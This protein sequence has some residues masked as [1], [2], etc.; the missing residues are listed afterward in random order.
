MKKVLFFCFVLLCTEALWAQY[1]QNYSA[2]NPA[3]FLYH[4][5]DVYL[6][7]PV[8]FNDGQQ[9]IVPDPQRYPWEATLENG[10]PNVT[11]DTDRD[12]MAIYLSSFISYSPTPPSKMGVLAYYNA[13]ETEPDAWNRAQ[14]ELYWFNPKGKPGDEA[15]SPVKKDG[16]LST[17]IVAVDIESV[18]LFEDK[19]AL[20]KPM[21]WIYLPQRES[22]NKVISAYEMDKTFNEQ[23]LLTGFW[24]MKNDRMEKQLNFT[25]DFINGDAHMNFYKVDGDYYFI[26][27]L[28][29][30]RSY[31]Q[32]GEVL[33]FERDPRKRYRRKTV[34]NVGPVLKSE[35]VDFS[36]A[37]DMATPQWEAYSVQPFQLD[38][39]EN[40]IWWGLVTTFGSA[41]FPDTEYKQRTELALTNDGVHWRW[42]KP[43]VPF[44]DNGP[45]P[46]SPDF[47]CIN[48]GKPV[49]YYAWDHTMKYLFYF[50]ASSP[51][52]H[53]AGRNSG[54]S[55]A[56]GTYGKIAGLH[57]D[58][59][60]KQFFSTSEDLTKG[61]PVEQLPTYSLASAFSLDAESFYPRIMADV[62]ED[63]R[64]KQLPQLNSYAAV[65]L[66]A[67]D[68]NQPHGMGHY[69][70]GSL[71]N[72][73]QGSMLPSDNFEAVSFVKG[74]EDGHSRNAMLQYLKSYSDEHPTEIVSIKDFPPVPVVMQAYV[75]NATLYS[76]QFTA[77]K[78]G[79]FP[80]DVTK[81][82][83]QQGKGVWTYTVP[84]PSQQ[85]TTIDFSNEP[86]LPNQQ[87]PVDQV[88]GT[89]ALQV[90]PGLTT[91]EEQTVFR[92]YK[93]GDEDNY[94]GIY[95]EPDKGFT[96]R[97]VKD[98]TIFATMQLL[99]PAGTTFE[100]KTV[101]LLLEAVPHKDRKMAP[102][103]KEESALFS[104]VCPEIGY[105]ASL[106][107]PI[108][109]EW[110]H[111]KGSITPSDSANARAFAYL[112]F[113]SF[114]PG[115]QKI[116]LGAKNEACASPF[117]GRVLK[118]EIAKKLPSG[119]AFFWP[120]GTMESTEQ[121]A[122]DRLSANHSVISVEP[123]VDAMGRKVLNI[124]IR[125]EADQ[126]ITVCLQGMDGLV[127]ETT[128][129]VS[130][131]EP[132]L[133][134]LSDLPLGQYTVEVRSEN[135][136]ARKDIN[137]N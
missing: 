53:V 130:G 43:G 75:K 47:G 19:T 96:Y 120:T 1:K 37:L 81:A 63:P 55:L 92:M 78:S 72:C 29:A 118:A 21:K 34:T 25:F 86:R 101:T 33:P 119:D 68:K 80:L 73:E 103:F 131:R 40:D 57:A 135:F 87:L 39:F 109:W 90:I 82:S 11:I 13:S 104:V 114:I 117:A 133:Y 137:I 56:V 110:R 23:G 20:S 30:K 41:G 89:L 6:D 58:A 123:L 31:L 66:Y 36:I 134:D 115:L 12:I 93:D 18:G 46:S 85:C 100:N 61:L 3:L 94:W 45:D 35:H 91:N 102:Y 17:N 67:Y 132:W 32:S 98:K 84:Q 70:C 59:Q 22:H 49:R 64:G 76:V 51:Q 10:M 97:L 77:K 95:Y 116:T 62:T 50:Y 15:I 4:D 108:L 7:N 24:Q 122:G 42:L 9:L 28:N 5:A 27:R 124:D 52:R 128:R 129:H 125:S 113:S 65:L 107:Q 69:L 54:V 26:T 8:K 88:S 127:R 99:P 48:I 74:G 2:L 106:Q 38:D 136:I 14:P 126:D 44:L 79:Q 16:Y 105:S 83:R 111:A 71:G 60:E 112:Q 121:P